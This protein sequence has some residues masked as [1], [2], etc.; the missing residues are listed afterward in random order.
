MEMII[1]WSEEHVKHILTSKGNI[2]IKNDI[3][4]NIIE[5]DE[6]QEKNYAYEAKKK[7]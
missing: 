2:G 7:K 4:I 3:Q 5:E 6:I 1:I